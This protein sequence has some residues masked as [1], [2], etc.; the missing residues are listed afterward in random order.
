[1]A[2]L[3]GARRRE[4]V[5]AAFDAFHAATARVLGAAGGLRDEAVHRQAVAMFELWLRREG[6]DGAARDPGLGPAFG[7]RLLGPVAA[8]AEADRSA[9]LAEWATDGPGRLRDLLAEAAP[10]AAGDPGLGWMGDVPLPP[11]GG[12]SRGDDPARGGIEGFPRLWRIGAGRVEGGGDDGGEFPVAV[13]LLDEAH[14][15][16][17]TTPNTRADGEALVERL[18]MRLLSAFRPGVLRVDVWDGSQYS[19]FPAMHPLSRTDLLVA[20]DPNRLD[21]LLE[22][23]SARIR[24]VHQQVLIEG[25][26]SVSAHAAAKGQRSEPWVVVVLA[27]HRSALPDEQQRQLQRIARSGLACGI[28]LVLL[29]LP[30]TVA[31]PVESVRLTET[32]VRCSMTGPA[33]E[34]APDPPLDRAAVTAA[35]TTIV[36]AHERWRALV[37]RFD[38]LLPAERGEGDSAPGLQTEIGFNDGTVVELRLDDSSPHAL[39]GGP[40]GS[41]KTNL[42][43]GMI[44]SLAARYR[45]DQLAFYLLDFKEGV[46]FAQFAPGRRD[47]TWLPHARLIGI[48]VNTDREFGLAL[49]QFLADEM[50]TRS[51]VAKA[52]EVTKLQEL[53]GLPDHERQWP[54]IVAV[55]DE[56]Q[57]L[58]AENDALAKRA[59]NLLEDV[60]RRGRSQGIHLVFA[61]QDVSGIEAFWGRPAIFE[62]FVLRIA[63]PRARRVLAQLNEVALTLPKWHAVIN[64]ESGIRHANEIARIPDAGAGSAV[65]QVQKEAHQRYAGEPPRLFDG[66]RSPSAAALVARVSPEDPVQAVLGQ[67][68]DIDGTAA[69]VRLPDAPGRNVAVLGSS[70]DAVRVLAAAARSLALTS[71]RARFLVAPLVGDTETVAAAVRQ[72]TSDPDLVTVTLT[73]FRAAVEDLAEQVRGRAAGGDRSPVFLLVQGADAADPLLERSGTDALRTVVRFGPEVGV[74][75]V[76]WWRSPMRLKQLLTLS[77]SPDDVGAWIGLDVQGAELAPFASM[78]AVAWSPRA[79]RGLFFDRAQHARPEVVLVP[80]PDEAAPGPGEMS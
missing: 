35:C 73:G 3:P 21:D 74:H 46:S 36:S 41:G 18:L 64:H 67:V 26:T 71:P 76:G 54:R 38:D 7:S 25:Y 77:A 42:L 47:Q 56:F 6:V 20:H 22:E 63:L 53:R 75:V 8:R 70:E 68:I 72:G 39:I 11:V 44:A 29:D 78:T 9:A 65:H 69:R 27:G 50:R 59:T 58:F 48:N 66:A 30:I 40:S 57:Y 23:L 1:M 2:G 12:E 16:V 24:R 80:G 32:D 60:A 37:R 4:R 49:L 62:Q 79:G 15:R 34:V 17:D 28:V 45:P 55:I 43:L 5:A 10:G 14:L 51:E 52:N 31:A 13:P 19:M 33:V 61:S